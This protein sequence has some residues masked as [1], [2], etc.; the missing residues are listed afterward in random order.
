MQTEEV[1]FRCMAR[2]GEQKLRHLK[3]VAALS[4]ASFEATGNARFHQQA[5]TQGNEPPV[6]E[7]RLHTTV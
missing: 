7:V 5:I 6:T 1:L 2:A 4:L 3:S